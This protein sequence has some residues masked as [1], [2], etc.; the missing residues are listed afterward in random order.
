MARRARS[1]ANIPVKVSYRCS[2]CGYENRDTIGHIHCERTTSVGFEKDATAIARAQKLVK[3]QVVNAMRDIEK[4]DF[5]KGYL[6]CKCRKCGKEEPWSKQENKL[7]NFLTIV[8]FVGSLFWALGL[9]N[10]STGRAFMAFIVG[11]GITVL[12]YYVKNQ[13][14]QSETSKLPRESLPRIT[15]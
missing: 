3:E 15:L 14:R 10:S 1:T 11:L 6:V 4:G 5:R 2:F 9:V 13:L 7:F 8:I 12:M